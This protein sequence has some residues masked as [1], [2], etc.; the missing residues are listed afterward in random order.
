MAA[1]GV[2]RTVPDVSYLLAHASHVL[3]TRMA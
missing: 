2:E 3:A 1:N